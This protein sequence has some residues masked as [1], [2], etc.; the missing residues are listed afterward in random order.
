MR[1]DELVI[2]GVDE[3][4][5]RL[6]SDAGEQVHIYDM[7]KYHLGWLDENLKPA[8][9]HPGKRIRPRFVFL[10]C[11]A[12]GAPMEDAIAPAA[13]VELVHNFSLVHDDIQD[14]S[15]YRRHRRTVWDIWGD[16]QAINAGDGLLVL[17]QL[18]LTDDEKATPQRKA[19]GLRILNIA[20][21]LLCEGQYLDLDYEQRPSVSL[22]EYYFM[23][24][25]KTGALL[26]AS[27]HLGALYG[28][29]DEGVITEYARFGRYLGLAFQAQD[30]Y[31]GIWGDPR[32][33]GK[34]AADDIISKKKALPMVRLLNVATGADHERLNA[35]LSRPGPTTQDET[36]EI[37]DLMERYQIVRFVAS[38]VARNTD[39]A[40]AA[41]EAAKPEPQA[42][43]ELASL[44]RKLTIRTS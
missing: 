4:I 30:D 38:E 14:R 37:L 40:L 43:E 2:Q 33:T 16:A 29:N 21:R 39:L 41:L 32:E 19:R 18:A 24:E 36:S 20:C 26:E 27:C 44:C 22:D 11:A 28:S 7:M 6:I 5:K 31:L 34:P 1:L 10:T 8:S 17:A 42:G 13:A 35:I 15:R 12:A 23:I 25:R 3:R 9:F